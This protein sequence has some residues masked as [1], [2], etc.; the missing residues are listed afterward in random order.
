VRIALRQPR[1]QEG[2]MNA[3]KGAAAPQ[4]YALIR[5]QASRFL[6]AK[7]LLSLLATCS[8]LS[9]GRLSA[10][11]GCAILA[12]LGPLLIWNVVRHGL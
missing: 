8:A 10:A 5:R 6:T 12:V 1:A 11:I 4:L 7:L 3:S 2:H 9:D